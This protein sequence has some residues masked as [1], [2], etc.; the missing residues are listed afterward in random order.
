MKKIK[1]NTLSFIILILFAFLPKLPY[2]DANLIKFYL[3]RDKEL[4]N[5]IFTRLKTTQENVVWNRTWDNLSD[6]GYGIWGDGTYIYT[7]G[8]TETA[9]EPI[10]RDLLLIKWDIDGN[11]LWN[12]TWGGSSL[13]SG[14]A[15]CGNGPYIYTCGITSSYAIGAYDMLLIKWDSS[16]NQLWNRTWGDVGNDYARAIWGDGIN[17]FICGDSEYSGENNTNSDLTVLKWDSEGNKIW[18]TTWGRYNNGYNNEQGSFIWGDELNL[19]VG[20][21]TQSH[22]GDE[23]DTDAVIIKLKG[24]V[25]GGFPTVD[26]VRSWASL[27]NHDDMFYDIWSDGIYL[28]TTGVT[29]GIGM[30]GFDVLLVKW[31]KNG[32]LIWNRTW[33]GEG[34]D[35]GMEIWGIGPFLYT[36]GYS[37]TFAGGCLVKWDING[38]QVWN[39]NWGKMPDD[40]PNAI[41]GDAD[42]IYTTGVYSSE[43]DA[44]LALVR[45][46]FDEYLKINLVYPTPLEN[47]VFESGIQIDIEIDNGL[48]ILDEVLYKWDG[49]PDIVWEEPYT[50]ILPAGDGSHTLYVSAK[51]TSPYFSDGQ[52]FI[53]ITDDTDPDVQIL[54]PITNDIWVQAPLYDLDITEPHL[55]QMWYTLNNGPTH[56]ITN[57]SGEISESAWNSVPNGEVNIKFYVTDILGHIG[58]DDVIV[59]KNSKAG[60]NEILQIIINAIIYGSITGV[61]GIGFFFIKRRLGKKKHKIVPENDT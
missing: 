13:E 1:K 58:S 43:G 55:D 20:G 16:G 7:C 45:W 14:L 36:C 46:Y 24:G 38:N 59:Q 33:G 34:N 11:Q 49:I 51:T 22:V 28:Y 5:D 2:F 31:D 57:S 26:W 41:W 19:Y 39:L 35:K 37:N 48:L 9:V 3:S 52:S 50:T 30:G 47:L 32:E 29:D 54:N 40:Y 60:E 61:V 53:F 12:R 44:D 21:F 8:S 6:I 25:M 18:N 42:S 4:N 17:I 15:I 10:D 23:V 56:F 27:G